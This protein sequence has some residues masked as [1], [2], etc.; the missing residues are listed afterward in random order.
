MKIISSQRYIDEKIVEQKLEQLAGKRSLVLEAWEVGMDDLAVL[1][2][3]HHRFEAA[4]RLGIPVTFEV[5]NHPEKITGE[6]LLESM[7]MDSDYYDIETGK[8]VW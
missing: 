8:N 1:A 5:T 4:Q 2:D 3:G 6:T 7:W